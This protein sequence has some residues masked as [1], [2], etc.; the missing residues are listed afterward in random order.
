V[1]I[2]GSWPVRTPRSLERGV[3]LRGAEASGASTRVARCARREPTPSART[4]LRRAP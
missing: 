1:L 3:W 2:E 4:G